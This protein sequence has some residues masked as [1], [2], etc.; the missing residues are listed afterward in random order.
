MTPAPLAHALALLPN[1][2]ETAVLAAPRWTESR[3]EA[4]ARLEL[5][6]YEEGTGKVTPIAVILPDC[7]FADRR[8]MT[9]APVWIAAL[10]TLLAEVWRRLE[11]QGQ[12]CPLAIALPESLIDIDAAK[13]AWPVIRDTSGLV[14]GRWGEGFD[15]TTGKPGVERL[16]PMTGAFEPIATVLRACPFDDKRL[17]ISAPEHIAALVAL[18]RDALR[19]LR[20]LEPPPAPAP[21]RGRKGPADHAQLAGILCGQRIFQV[22]LAE[23]HGVESADETRAAN[24]VR[25]LC[26][27]TSRA[28]LNTNPAAAGAWRR[29]HDEFQLWRQGR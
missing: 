15:T 5:C 16:D 20:A 27:V 26:R 24:R 7:P 23:R 10:L 9:N 1:I 29:L 18:V 28:E 17:L 25:S 2:V 21:P 13:G 22:F 8:L 14:E 3:N 19:R 6:L 4:A 12:P 11:A